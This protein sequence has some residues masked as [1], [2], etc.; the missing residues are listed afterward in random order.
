MCRVNPVFRD[1]FSIIR[2]SKYNMKLLVYKNNSF[3]IKI[4][5]LRM[6]T[7]SFQCKQR[8]IWKFPYHDN[9]FILFQVF[10][11]A[12]EDFFTIIIIQL[13][14]TFIYFFEFINLIKY[15]FLDDSC[16]IHTISR[17]GWYRSKQLEIQL[18]WII[19]IIT[20]VLFQNS[21]AKLNKTNC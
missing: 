9:V 18:S 21:T 16:L 2:Q 17:F 10:Y 12:F 3:Q 6:R 8:P 4:Q 11:K 13:Y 7:G 15:L 20:Y 5:Y 1:Y 14:V 19:T